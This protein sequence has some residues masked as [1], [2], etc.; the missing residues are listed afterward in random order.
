MWGAAVRTQESFTWLGTEGLGLLITPLISPHEFRAHLGLYRDAFEA[1]HGG[2]DLRPRI[3]ASLPLLVADTDERANELAELYLRRY[4]DVWAEAVSP[5]DKRESSAYRGYSG[6]GWMLRGLQPDKLY[7]EGAAIVGSPATVIDRIRTFNDHIGGVDQIL[8]Q[9][10][11][12]AMPLNEAR[13]S[14]EL[15]CDKVLPEVKTL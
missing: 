9:I 3:A 7:T 2:T 8:W 1:A 15:F 10:D 14:L 4:L 11:F 6:F 13:R 5:W 12:G